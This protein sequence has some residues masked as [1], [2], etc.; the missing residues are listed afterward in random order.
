MMR[1][2][3]QDAKVQMGWQG[4][5]G[6]VLL[7]VAGVLHPLVV[8]PLETQTSHMRHRLD[9]AQSASHGPGGSRKEVA[10][11]YR[12]MPRE[13]DV[14]DAMASIYAAAD[15]SDVK[16]KE[17][18]FHLENDDGPVVGYV[19]DFPMVGKY[20]SIRMLVSRVLAHNA[21]MALDQ[22]DLKRDRISDAMLR[23][24]VR[25]TLFLRKTK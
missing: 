25:F 10:E 24:N 8:E 3:W 6:V 9:T 23:A 7:A 11:F 16:L 21:Y 14:N 18:S 17:A 5:L 20:G 12:D 4:M 2:L 1:K 13:K 15:A 19:M 22:I